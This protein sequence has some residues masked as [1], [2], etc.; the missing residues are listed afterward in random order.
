M[1]IYSNIVPESDVRKIQYET[2]KIIS[3][4][5]IKC[6]GPNGSTTGFIKNMDANGANIAVEYTKDGHT[7]IKN[8]Q[9]LNPIE[10]AVQ[11]MLTD[12]T[13]YIVK[14]V[15]D[16]TT[17]AIVL[18]SA[19]FNKLYNDDTLR[20][21]HPS[22]VVSK[23]SRII[24]EVKTEILKLGREATVEDI[25]NIALIS[26]NNNEN[27]SGIIKQIYD[28]YGM[29]VFIDVGISNEIDTIVKE[30]DGMTLE[31]GYSHMCM[32]NDHEHNTATV[33]NP[34]IYCFADP[35]DTP[36]MLGFLQT[37]IGSNIMDAYTRGSVVEPVPT[38]IFCKSISP[39]TSSYFESV[40]KLMTAVPN[41]PLLIVSDIH[42]SYIYED[43]VQM[44]GAKVIKKY[45]NPDLQQ[46]DIDAEL[47]PT[48]ET[49]LDFC[50]H[51]DQVTADEFKTKVIRPAAMY[52]DDG[53]YSELYNTM[54][55]YLEGQVTK[56]INENAGITEI[57]QTKR[58]LNC[59]KSN[60]VDL[61]IGGMAL[62]DRNNLKASVEDAVLNCRSAAI[63]GVGYGAN[64]MAFSVLNKMDKQDLG[65]DNNFIDILYCAYESLMYDLYDVP[66]D[67]NARKDFIKSMI[68][69]GCPLNI[70]T[71]EYDGKVLS[72]IKTD[73][74]ILDTIKNILML[75]FTANQF[76]VQS[77]MHNVY[78]GEV[79][80]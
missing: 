28:K 11:D 75:M 17:S 47:A 4:S 55:K 43:I 72:S 14:E 71:N 76:L 52:D 49:I 20:L 65:K 38:V 18:C 22:D 29:D 15:G 24:E 68:D 62:S 74:C 8:I 13:R 64:Y 45:L 35:I 57:Q 10:R 70:R 67:A 23:F 2:L 5:L 53:N 3:E 66:C 19:V 9:F 44:C 46:K 42:Q 37:I 36:E 21:A 63:N 51:A 79:K 54:L 34:K 32:I 73:V 50:G 1:K 48:N 80:E 69:N 12:L 40:V 27:I 7:I 25:Y 61:L 26:T 30:Y 41:V 59:F 6:F 31:T 77:P 16:G 56:A 78:S 60:M 33:R 39:D 58:R